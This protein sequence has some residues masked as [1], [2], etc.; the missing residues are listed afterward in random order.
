MSE[1]MK[2]NGIEISAPLGIGM[3]ILWKPD[4]VVEDEEEFMDMDT[5]LLEDRFQIAQL[6]TYT[7]EI[8]R[9]DRW[10]PIYQGIAAPSLELLLESISSFIAITKPIAFARFEKQRPLLFAEISRRR[11]EADKDEETASGA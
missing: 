7:L 1:L 10:E 4:R 9:G 11:K 8:R 3:R 5:Y 2:K 6:G